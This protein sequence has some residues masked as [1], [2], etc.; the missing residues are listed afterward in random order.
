MS[1]SPACTNIKNSVRTNVPRSL[2][3]TSDSIIFPKFKPCSA[4]IQIHQTMSCPTA[5]RW[6]VDNREYYANEADYALVGCPA[7]LIRREID[8]GNK[9]PFATYPDG[10]LVPISF[11]IYF[12]KY[13]ESPYRCYDFAGDGRMLWA[14][15]D[16]TKPEH[17]EEMKKV[18][19]EH[20]LSKAEV[21]DRYKAVWQD[22]M[23]HLVKEPFR[24]SDSADD[25]T[26]AEKEQM[27]ADKAR[28]AKRAFYTSLEN[29][30]LE[31]S[32]LAH[33]LDEDKESEKRQLLIELITDQTQSSFKRPLVILLDMIDDMRNP[34]P[35][36]K[37]GYVVGYDVTKD[38]LICKAFFS[39]KNHHPLAGS[40]Y[41]DSTAK[42]PDDRV[43]FTLSPKVFVEDFL[44]HSDA[45]IH[46][47]E[48]K[49]FKEIQPTVSER[50]SGL[51]PYLDTSDDETYPYVLLTRFI[52]ADFVQ[53]HGV[54][55]VGYDPALADDADVDEIIRGPSI[56]RKA[57]KDVKDA[58]NR[59]RIPLVAKTE[60]EDKRPCLC[61]YLSIFLHLCKYLI[62][63][64]LWAASRGK[65]R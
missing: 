22:L 33:L 62:D 55:L 7:K 10:S 6:F 12:D 28:R 49:T 40:W 31:G 30:E 29:G 24:D 1:Q 58:L 21:D 17:K 27:E 44:K 56:F 36:E 50:D 63:V 9:R 60:Q 41:G 57:M 61:K 5:A 37:S 48:N 20:T 38:L 53:G 2:S 19:G 8:E 43:L 14:D 16:D 47:L 23:P 11:D 54:D 25:I 4:R 3:S 46:K 13:R 32:I 26:D 18:L 45:L 52:A 65:F 35:G 34:N 15:V 51:T 59:M 39:D 64:L 42:C